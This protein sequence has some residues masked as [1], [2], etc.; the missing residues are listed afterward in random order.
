MKTKRK[1]LC[2]SFRDIVKF[3]AS[4]W[5]LFN[6]PTMIKTASASQNFPEGG[7]FKQQSDF[8]KGLP[9]ACEW[10]TGVLISEIAGSENP[11]QT[12]SDRATGDMVV[13]V[14]HHEFNDEFGVVTRRVKESNAVDSVSQSTVDFEEVMIGGE[15]QDGNSQPLTFRFER[16]KNG[17]MRP[18]SKTKVPVTEFAEGIE[19]AKEGVVV[20]A[21]NNQQTC[22]TAQLKNKRT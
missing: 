16:D 21:Q 22:Y 17:L 18:V 20:S 19:Q 4:A 5:L 9:P 13:K 3:F 14:R 2:P 8:I 6:A 11:F 10:E 12:M 15:S 1:S 7:T